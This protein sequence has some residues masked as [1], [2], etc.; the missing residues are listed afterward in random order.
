MPKYFSCRPVRMG[1][2]FYRSGKISSCCFSLDPN[3][4][5]GTINDSITPQRI[6]AFQSKLLKS[7]R[8]GNA[9]KSCLSCPNFQMGEWSDHLEGKFTEVTLN[10]YKAC[11]LKCTHCGYR[12][13]DSMEHDTPHEQ[14]LETIQACINAN[15]CSE[16]LYLG[17]GGGEPSLSKGIHDIL[18]YALDNGWTAD[19]NSNAAKFSPL[20]AEG[21]NKG[22]FRLWLTPDAGTPE[23][24]L[25]IK[26]VDNFKNA[27]RN[28]KL[29]MLETNGQALVKF[30][31]EEGNIEDVPNM[32]ITA[33]KNNVNKIVLSFD[34]NIKPSDFENYR[35]PIHYFLQLAEQNN[36]VVLKGALLQ[37]VLLKFNS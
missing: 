12:K 21:V 11:N 19:I 31:L 13:N 30:I 18:Q 23:T 17:V 2:N 28:I 33:K 36:I 15:I 9:P 7:H 25:K 6:M 26:G 3:L 35:K 24:Y 16:K 22:N 32:I 4:V 5:I 20:F 27:W 10:H 8:L 34:M 37:D 1:F 29:Y 14:V